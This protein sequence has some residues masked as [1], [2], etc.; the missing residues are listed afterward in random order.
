MS[1]AP[2]TAAAD[3]LSTTASTEAPSSALTRYGAALPTV[4]APTSVPMARPR[5]SRNQVETIFIA[6]GYTPAMKSPVANRVATAALNPGAAS[7][8]ALAAAAPSA[9]VATSARSGTRSA[10]L[11]SATSAVPTTKPSCTALVSHA[12]SAG[13]RSQRSRSGSATALAVNQ[14]D[15]PSSSATATSAK[16]RRR[17]EGFAAV[18]ISNQRAVCEPFLLG[19]KAIAAR[20]VCYARGPFS[21]SFTTCFF[22]HPMLFIHPDCRQGS[23]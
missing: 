18:A 17:C 10:R 7:S 16:V 22:I 2:T 3:A 1:A 4:R 12:A 21:P 5:P 23:R 15:M 8:A 13:A 20:G 11:S 6:G 14:T 9:E 19:Q